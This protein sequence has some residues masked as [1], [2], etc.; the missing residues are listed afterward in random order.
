[1]R[2][3]HNHWLDSRCAGKPMTLHSTLRADRPPSGLVRRMLVSMVKVG[4]VRMIVLPSFV[5][6]RVAVFPRHC[7]AMLVVVMTVIVPVGVLVLERRVRMSVAVF[8]GEMQK[9]A[10]HEA[11][12]GSG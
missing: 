7:W 9:N 1:M 6:V 3:A 10:H 11:Q 2:L 5:H 12:R 4:S 8:F